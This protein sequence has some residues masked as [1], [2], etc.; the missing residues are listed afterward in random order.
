MPSSGCD[1][2]PPFCDRVIVS[3]LLRMCR[4]GGWTPPAETLL[5][6]PPTRLRSIRER[7]AA[8]PQQQ[9]GGGYHHHFQQ[10]GQSAFQ[11]GQ[12][13]QSALQRGQ[14]P[15]RGGQ[16]WSPEF[17]YSSGGGNTTAVAY[18]QHFDVEAGGGA[19]SSL[20]HRVRTPGL[21]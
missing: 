5:G 1:K 19:P 10:H 16:V 20:A 17:G 15:G 9:Q 8:H 11:G 6:G 7:A 13:D 2:L 4:F 14:S 3:A 21:V 18:I 12:H